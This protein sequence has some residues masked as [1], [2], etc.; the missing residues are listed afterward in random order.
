[1][2]F[3]TSCPANLEP[4]TCNSANAFVNAEVTGD[5]TLSF[6]EFRSVIPA[7]TLARHPRAD[8][9]NIFG[10]ADKDG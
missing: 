10:Q 8:L 9:Q 7:A 3:D 5:G 1:M 6:D 2:T 4:P